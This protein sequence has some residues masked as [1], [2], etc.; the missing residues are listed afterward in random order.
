[1]CWK[2]IDT[3]QDP[4]YSWKSLLK[5]VQW[6][7]NKNEKV[8]KG[9]KLLVMKDWSLIHESYTYNEKTPLPG[10]SARGAGGE[11]EPASLLVKKKSL[12]P[13][14]SPFCKKYSIWEQ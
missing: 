7:P 3:F 11:V 4:K 13:L 9:G 8:R 10:L 14:L 2:R 12:S 6:Q 1:M 5:V